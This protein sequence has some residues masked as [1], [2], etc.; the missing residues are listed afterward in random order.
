MKKLLDVSRSGRVGGATAPTAVRS[1]G[2]ER[3]AQRAETSR[4]RAD[5]RRTAKDQSSRSVV[6]GARLNRRP[7]PL[8]TVLQ[9]DKKSCEELQKLY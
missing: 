8:T 9:Q 1:W 2:R 3:A 7:T 5:G 6:D 4:A